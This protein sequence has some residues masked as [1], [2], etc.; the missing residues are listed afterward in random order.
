[1]LSKL[2]HNDD[3]AQQVAAIIAMTERAFLLGILV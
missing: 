1:M 2:R 3:I